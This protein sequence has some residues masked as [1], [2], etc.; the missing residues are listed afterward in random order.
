M[1]IRKEMLEDESNAERWMISYAD[2]YNALVCL[3]CRDVR[4]IVREQ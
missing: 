2:F 1:S 3:L 4:D